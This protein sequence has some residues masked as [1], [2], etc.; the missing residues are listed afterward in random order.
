[1]VR[2]LIL[3]SS[4]YSQYTCNILSFLSPSC[5]LWGRR[6]QLSRA[7]EKMNGLDGC[8]CERTCSV[9][10][11][12]YREDEG[13]TDGCRNCT[14]TVRLHAQTDT[15]TSFLC[16]RAVCVCARARASSGFMG[17]ETYEEQGRS[18]SFYLARTHSYHYIY[19]Q[20]ECHQI[21]KCLFV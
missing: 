19:N 16:R 21:D 10:G 14:C 5:L 17:V 18:F 11:V 20:R 6:E 15:G 8:Y 3:A 12:V 4:I 7:E 13:W 9:K 2:C 1:M